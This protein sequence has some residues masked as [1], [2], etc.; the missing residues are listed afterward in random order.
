M[1]QQGGKG[2][3]A[4]KYGRHQ[5]NCQAYKAREALGK[6]RKT[7]R[8]AKL[9]AERPDAAPGWML[10]STGRAMRKV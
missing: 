5:K 1:A 10:T 4:R 6:T 9:L 3:G 8:L 7:R 2:G